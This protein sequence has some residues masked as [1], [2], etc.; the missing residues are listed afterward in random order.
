MPT[1]LLQPPSCREGQYGVSSS[2]ADRQV[3]GALS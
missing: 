1:A 2:L 3:S